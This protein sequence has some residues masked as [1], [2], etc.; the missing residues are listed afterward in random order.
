M[1]CHT[2]QCTLS[3]SPQGWGKKQIV[4]F[5]RRQL[6]RAEAI[7]VDKDGTFVEL[8][9]R[10][11]N[12]DDFPRKGKNKSGK[13]VSSYK[14]PDKKGHYPSYRIVLREG[15]RKPVNNEQ[16]GDSVDG[17][18]EPEIEDVKLTDLYAYLKKEENDE[19]SI[20]IRQ[21]GI[22]QSRRRVKTTVQKIESYIKRRRHK[23]AAKESAPPAWQGIVMLVLGLFGLLLALLLGQFWEE[24]SPN[25]RQS[26]PGTRN[27]STPSSKRPV[28][29]GKSAASRRSGY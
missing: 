3:I 12:F 15:S 29:Y 2:E 27:R 22:S 23:L 16:T 8:S 11:D 13:Q 28:Q 1:A 10:L 25:R 20:T 21:F 4:T 14:G 26:G 9:P 7:K 18:A 24:S 17:A 6:L 19:Y 5:P